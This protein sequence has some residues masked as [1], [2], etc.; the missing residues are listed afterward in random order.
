[1][2][3]TIIAVI[4]FGMAS[5]VIASVEEDRAEWTRQ[6]FA[7]QGSPIPD[8]GV[9]VIP[10]S[11]MSQYKLFKHEY[12][13]NRRD[14]AQFGYIKKSSPEANSLLGIKAEANKQ[15]TKYSNGFN[16]TFD[17]NLRQSVDEIK[18][19][20]TFVGV[21]HSEMSEEI[22]VAP[23]LTYLKNEGWVGAIQYFVNKDIGNCSF[24][25]NN[26]RLSHG[27][28]VVA[29]ELAREDVNGK[30]TVVTVSG[31][32]EDG[33]LYEVEWYDQTFFRTLQCAN[34]LFDKSLVSK[35]ID[36]AK[37]IDSNQ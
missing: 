34:K 6:Y 2:K 8:G 22:G 7:K 1:M 37:T 3:K 13:R 5:N 17:T 26:V 29:K 28:V 36:L 11:K 4:I 12:E 35:S 30:V 10:E 18:M 24:A 19:A 23:Y 14:V 32:N 25:E 20:Y 15:F 33:F 31:D 9:Q 27:S 21:P 16:K